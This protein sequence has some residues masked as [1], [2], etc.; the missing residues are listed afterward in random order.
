[1]KNTRTGIRLRQAQVAAVLPAAGGTVLACALPWPPLV[2][3]VLALLPLACGFAA[4]RL[5]GR[6]AG[7]AVAG[8]AAV[9]DRVPATDHEL[10]PLLH[11]VLPVWQQHVGTVR[12]QTD[13]A[14]NQLVASL[15]SISD[16]FEAAGFKTVGT[17]TAGTS[18]TLDL[19]TRCETELQPVIEAMNRISAS[20]GAMAA[21][22]NELS[23]ATGELQGM[24]SDVGRIAQQT[25]LLAINAAIEAA[26]AGESGRGFS[27]IA[28]E[29]RRLSQDSAAT[30]RQIT[31]RIAQV[32]KAMKQA[33]ESALHSAEHDS[34]ATAQSGA[35]VQSVL[36]HVRELGQGAE[37]MLGHGQAI[38]AN[39]E[40]LITGLQFQDRISQVITAVGDDMHRLHETI[41]RGDAAPPASQWLED[42]QQRYTMREQRIGHAGPTG[43]AHESVPAAPSRAAVFF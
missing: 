22:V 27:V 32:G 26:R 38:R 11:E 15:A 4:W 37:S 42:L 39:L 30:A 8:L 23:V 9:V 16:Q 6:S 41:E 3:L 2:V 43:A 24:A 40:A 20:K 29:V 35:M 5:I 34:A 13:E 10:A 14:V 21:S 25:N 31:E 36:G 18:A 28:A 1:M 12:T 33:S 7:E 17:D 19:L